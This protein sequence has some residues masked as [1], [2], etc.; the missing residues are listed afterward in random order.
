MREH[1]IEAWMLTTVGDGGVVRM[2]DLHIDR[3]DETWKSREYWIQGGLE[4]FRLALM[5]RD[6]HQIPFV[7]ALGFSLESGE[8][9]TDVNFQ[10]TKELGE[11]LNWTPPSLYLFEPGKTPRTN[12]VRE[13]GAVEADLVVREL[14]RDLFGDSVQPANCYYIEFRQLQ[15]A[16]YS[17]SVFLEG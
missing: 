7:V 2:D 9:F 16:E 14:N 4:A 6:R 12:A 13:D 1:S 10:N 15:S 17:R 3:V 5:L 11:K 8:H